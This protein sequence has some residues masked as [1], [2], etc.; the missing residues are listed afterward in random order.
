VS[1][2]VWITAPRLR[3][4]PGDL[5]LT[6]SEDPT[7]LRAA[8]GERLYLSAGQHCRIVADAEHPARWRMQVE[9]YVYSV[10]YT[11][12]ATGECFAWHWHPGTRPDFHMHLMAL[13]AAAGDLSRFHVPAGPISFATVVRFLIAE[14]EVRP[15]RP[16]WTETLSRAELLPPAG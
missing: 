4:E 9:G 11:P 7:L 3:G 12:E 16:D 14:L 5:A 15:L 2:A 13:H 1:P 6:L 10:R 8:S